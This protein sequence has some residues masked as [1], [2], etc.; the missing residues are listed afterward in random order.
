MKKLLVF[1]T[2]IVIVFSFSYAKKKNHL[3]LPEKIIIYKNGNQ[4]KINKNTEK[5]TKLFNLAQERIPKTLDQ[6]KSIFF[7][8]EIEEL[9]NKET[10]MVFQYSKETKTHFKREYSIFDRIFNRTINIKYTILVFPLTGD[11]CDLLLFTNDSDT[12]EEKASYYALGRLLSADRILKLID[13]M[14]F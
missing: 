1:I 4:H 13:S 6:T 2:I 14:E 10:M 12:Y 9:T 5:Y 3:Q 7:K 11:I 8:K